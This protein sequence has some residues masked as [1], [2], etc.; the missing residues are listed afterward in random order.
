[1]N[2]TECS[3]IAHRP[4]LI[5]RIWNNNFVEQ[6]TGYWIHT[7]VE[8][9]QQ[10]WTRFQ[11][12][13]KLITRQAPVRCQVDSNDVRVF[14]F[15]TEFDMVARRSNSTRQF[16]CADI[17]SEFDRRA[18]RCRNGRECAAPLKRSVRNGTSTLINRSKKKRIDDATVVA[19]ANAGKGSLAKVKLTTHNW[20]ISFRQ[21]EL[22]Q[23]THHPLN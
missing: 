19:A 13:V 18:V 22:G 16:L 20:L 12:Q 21:F 2:Y 5:R 7:S 17:Q 23:L 9:Q 1:M 11:V 3:G 8:H 15:S 14:E 4:A 10:K 6:L